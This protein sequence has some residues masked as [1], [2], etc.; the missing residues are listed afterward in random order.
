MG[1]RSVRWDGRGAVRREEAYKE[2]LGVDVGVFG[3]VEVLL[4]YEYAFCEG[5]LAGE[6]MWEWW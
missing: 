2:V 1:V 3:E 5:G 4:G 6:I